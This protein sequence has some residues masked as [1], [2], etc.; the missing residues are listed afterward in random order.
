MRIREQFSEAD[1]D[2]C[3]YEYDDSVVLAAD[4]G[5]VP[6]ASVDVVGETVIVVVDGDQFE[7]EVDGGAQAFIKNGVLTIE[8]SA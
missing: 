2:V 6:S 3:Q 1:V 7:V 8:V 5:Y 4:F